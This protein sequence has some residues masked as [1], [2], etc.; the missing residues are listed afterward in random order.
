[1]SSRCLSP[2]FREGG[3]AG[4]YRKGRWEVGMSV[5]L[6]VVTE[7]T[8]DS[9]L[10]RTPGGVEKA[11]APLPESGGCVSGGFCHLHR[12]SRF[13]PEWAIDP[14]GHLTVSTNRAVSEWA[15]EEDRSTR[16]ANAGATVGLHVT[17]SFLGELVDPRGLDQLLSMNEVTLRD[18]IARIKMKLGLRAP[19]NDRIRRKKKGEVSC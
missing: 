1:M 3:L 14:R 12:W 11:H 17:R 9:L 4:R 7:E 8:V 2:C 18:V 13:Q 19:A 16:S 15:C 10:V 5:A 6:A